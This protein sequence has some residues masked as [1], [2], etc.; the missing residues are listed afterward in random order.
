LGDDIF[1]V[2]STSDVVTESAGQGTDTVQTSVQL[3][4]TTWIS[5]IENLTFLGTANLNAPTTASTANNVIIGN[6]GNN[7][8]NGGAGDDTLT[9]GGGSDTLTGGTGADIYKYA[10]GD[11]SDTIDNS[12]ADSLT[13]RLQFTNLASN[14]VTFAHTGNNL[15]I[16]VTGGSTITATN[17]FSATGNRI[18]FLNFTNGEYTAS[19][20]DTAANGGGTLNG[21][22]PPAAFAA[23]VAGTGVLRDFSSGALQNG[24][25]DELAVADA[26]ALPKTEGQALTIGKQA[27][28][29]SHAHWEPIKNFLSNAPATLGDT[30][31][32]VDRISSV[33][34]TVD[35]ITESAA[36][37]GVNRLIE[38]IALFG[39]ERN[40]GHSQAFELGGIDPLE[41]LAARQSLASGRELG[42]RHAALD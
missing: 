8:I 16:T 32:E 38:A 25:S 9:G 17:W 19:Q 30:L 11:G 3:S 29:F 2:D 12:A 4:T 6:S 1:V 42:F 27:G 37:L 33:R 15:V 22:S 10:S 23:P 34:G 39:V 35:S 24:P 5:N 40:V 26:F 14:Q 28:S 18:D 41:Q 36:L 7:I 13:D 20:V 31:S 21:F